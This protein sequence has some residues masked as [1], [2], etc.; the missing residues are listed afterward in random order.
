MGILSETLRLESLDRERSVEMK[1]LVDTGSFYTLVPAKLLKELEVE[2]FDTCTL[3]LADGR[4]VDH[5]VGEAVATVG[6]RTVTT[7][8][9]FGGDDVEPLLGAYTLEGLLLTVDPVNTQLVPR[10]FRMVSHP[11]A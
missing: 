6:E 5:D 11:T 4:L 2:P 3:E 10:K 7:L 9:L 8:V 1:A